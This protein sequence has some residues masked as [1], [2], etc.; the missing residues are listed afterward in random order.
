MMTTPILVDY[1][2]KHRH[3]V[4]S[5]LFYSRR[6]HSHLDWYKTGQWLDIEDNIVQ[7]AYDG[8]SKLIGVLGLSAPLNAGSWVRLLAIAQDY[9]IRLVLNVLWQSLCRRIESAGIQTVAI[10]LIN[11][12]LSTYL[13]MMDFRYIEDVVTMHRTGV[14]LPA[15]LN[16]PLTLRNGYSEDIADII[17]VDHAAFASPWQ[18]TRADIYNSQRQAASCTLA[19]YKGRVVGYEISTRHHTSGH[20]ARLAVMPQIQGKR[21][22]AVLLHNLINKFNRR[23]VRSMTVNTQQ[24][25]IRSQRLYI[26]YGFHRNGF[27]LPIWQWGV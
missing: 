8:N 9:D 4:L 16:H 21:V 20:L 2:R 1:K 19:E 23:G 14:D 26:R 12:W 13:P 18:M 27:D 15:A 17:H 7:L 6:T 3:D 25:N 10:L 24:S 5:L 22:G 11:T